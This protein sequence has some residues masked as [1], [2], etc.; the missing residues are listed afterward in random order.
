MMSPEPDLA[1]TLLMLKYVHREG[2]NSKLYSVT[3]CLLQICSFI[4]EPHFLL[5]VICF[6]ANCS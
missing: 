3:S 1:M 6:L 2:L 4:A 5:H